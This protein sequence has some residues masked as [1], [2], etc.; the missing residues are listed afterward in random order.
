MRVDITLYRED[1]LPEFDDVKAENVVEGMFKQL[2]RYL[3]ALATEIHFVDY[4]R[5]VTKVIKDRNS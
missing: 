4:E 5:G 3:Y 2:P 1:L